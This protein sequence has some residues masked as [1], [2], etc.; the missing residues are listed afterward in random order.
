MPL[1]RYD[2]LDPEKRARLLRAA[3]AEFGQKGFEG[4]SLNEIL[5]ASGLGK[6]SYYYYFAD[7]ED[8]FATVIEQHLTA[9]AAAAT[10][11]LDV[12]DAAAFWSSVERF[13][14]ACLRAIA[15]EP[16][17]LKL[18]RC[19]QAVRHVPGPRLASA[20]AWLRSAQVRIV[21]AGRA[22]GFVRE[23]LDTQQLVALVEA[24]DA[25]LDATLYA[26]GA[27]PSAERLEAHLQLA[28]DTS[29]RL[30][31]PARGA[32]KAA[33]VRRSTG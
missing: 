28:L 32:G 3:A 20:F 23:D 2:R 10:L 19:L 14:L 22:H 7:K 33:R 15:H 16:D 1:P 13:Q 21:E 24:A 27:E 6:S 4:A 8:L 5:A 17:A 9:V 26:E 18:F 11:T 29:R 12:A 31:E 25:A 30:L